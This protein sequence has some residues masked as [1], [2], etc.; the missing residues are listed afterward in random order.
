MKR[1]KKRH[2]GDEINSM[3]GKSWRK[4]K[5]MRNK[6]GKYMGKGQIKKGRREKKENIERKKRKKGE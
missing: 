3:A 6:N 2:E 5:K 4:E 1:E